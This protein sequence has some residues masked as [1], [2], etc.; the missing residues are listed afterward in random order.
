[1]IFNGSLEEFLFASEIVPERMYMFD[2]DLHTGLSVIWNVG[3]KATF[4]IDKTP[5]TVGKNCIIFIT[6]LHTIDDYKF[7]NLRVIQ[8]NKPFYCVENHDSQVGCKGL[9][10]FGASSVP[11][12][13][14]AKERSRAF[15]LLWEILIMEIEEQDDELK[16]EM[17]RILLKRF[18]I[19]CVRIFKNQNYVGIKESTSIGLIREYNFLVEKYYKSKTTVADYAKMLFKSPKTLSNLFK[20]HIDKTPLQIISERRLLEAKRLLKYSD[21]SIQE[22]AD[23]LAFSDIQAFSN[24]F[25]KNTQLNPTAFKTLQSR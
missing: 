3:K 12:I 24:F 8:F 15:E 19:L 2:Q 23:E 20:K 17:L 22:I 1:M 7:E 18:L 11:K 5:I 14:I 4:T 10:F 6:G 13:K 25:K 21:K 16:I 9:L